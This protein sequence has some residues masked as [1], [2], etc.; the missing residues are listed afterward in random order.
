MGERGKHFL[1]CSP[2]RHCSAPMITASY[3]Y[4]V[5]D[6]FYRKVNDE[7]LVDATCMSLCRAAN[8]REMRSVAVA[9]PPCA[10]AAVLPPCRPMAASS[11]QRR[12]PLTSARSEPSD[13]EVYQIE[14]LKRWPY[15][16]VTSVTFARPSERLTLATKLDDYRTK[17]RC[18]LGEGQYFDWALVPHNFY[19]ASTVPNDEALEISPTRL[20]RPQERWIQVEYVMF[21]SS[22]PADDSRL[23]PA[24]AR[25]A[26]GSLG[27][28]G[29]PKA[30]RPE[31][32][33]IGTFEDPHYAWYNGDGGVEKAVTAL[34]ISQPSNLPYINNQTIPEGAEYEH[35]TACVFRYRPYKVAPTYNDCL[36]DLQAYC[37]WFDH[38]L[39]EA[40]P[41]PSGAAARRSVRVARANRRDG[42][43]KNAVKRTG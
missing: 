34:F 17:Y 23:V 18:Y 43:K 24:R 29:L 36:K 31:S 13:V 40:Q 11:K 37:R 39:A 12:A 5:F 3:T 26:S 21:F 8:P 4:Y 30:L 10:G 16:S 19:R 35:V 38:Y 9:V 32:V 25:H 14:T 20:M 33:K 28:L 42:A 41:Q 15:Q 6:L 2:R 22:S 1:L 27:F 7:M